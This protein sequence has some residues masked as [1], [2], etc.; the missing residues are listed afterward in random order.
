MSHRSLFVLILGLFV[1]CQ[2]VTAF[3]EP[4]ET[5]KRLAQAEVDLEKARESLH[6]AHQELGKKAEAIN[7]LERL[8]EKSPGGREK[9]EAPAE[10]MSQLKRELEAANA[11][12]RALENEIELEAVAAKRREAAVKAELRR[13]ELREV[14]A[15]MAEAKEIE[16]SHLAAEPEIF[17]VSYDL[18]SAANLEGRERALKWIQGKLE[19]NRE[20]RFEIRGQANDTGFKE[21][22]RVIAENR[23]NFLASFLRVSGVPPRSIVDVAGGESVES[24][25]AGRIVEVTLVP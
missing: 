12:I 24:G 21:A 15:Q 4:T 1:F 2:G 6:E 11:R 25:S 18:N 3:A 7:R 10:G 16:V 13:L 8:L 9:K 23:A 20:V 22:N 5:A 14:K 19:K 17:R